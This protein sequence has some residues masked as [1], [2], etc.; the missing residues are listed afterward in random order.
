MRPDRPWAGGRRLT[1]ASST[2]SILRPVLAEISTAL[3]A[4]RPMTSS[5]WALDALRLG[6]RQVDLVED[7]HNLVIV[8]KGLVDIGQRLRL[9]TLAGIHNEQRSFA[10]GERP[11]DLVG[12]VDVTWRVH[13]IECVGL[14][15]FP[16][17][18]TG[19][20]SAP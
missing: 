7:R 13:Q 14:A 3:E 6:G 12:E 4:S 20:R 1:I 15:V 16:P 18:R 10:G 5:I 19:E 9:D 11:A 2:P 8:I 17:C